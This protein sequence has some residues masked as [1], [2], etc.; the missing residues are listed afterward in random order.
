MRVSVPKG[1]LCTIKCPFYRRCDDSVRL[2]SPPAQNLGNGVESEVFGA[3]AIAPANST[4][5]HLTADGLRGKTVILGDPT[6]DLAS[7]S[8]LAVLQARA[9]YLFDAAKAVILND[10]STAAIAATFTPGVADLLFAQS[11][12]VQS[13]NAQLGTLGL[14]PDAQAALGITVGPGGNAKYVDSSYSIPNYP[15][16]TTDNFSIPGAQNN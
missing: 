16:P 13:W 2:P 15:F 3:V 7:L 6:S 4:V 14:T 9:I 10:R 8:L 11:G 12:F 1:P 5:Q